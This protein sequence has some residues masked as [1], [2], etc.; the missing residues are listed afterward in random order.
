M[1]N[2]KI[3]IEVHVQLNTKS[4]LFC[5]CSNLES[6]EPNS[7]TCATCLGHPGSK[8]VLNKKAFEKAIKVAIALGCKINK[9]T[10]FSRKSYFYPDLAKNFQISQYEIPIG[11]AGKFEGINIRRLHLEED[12]A[13][14]IHKGSIS[15]IDYNRSGTPLIEIVTEPDFK[16]PNEVRLFLRKLITMLTYLDV[17]HKKG[18]STL[19]ADANIS[20]HGERVEIKNVNGLKDIERALEYEAKRQETELQEKQETRGWDSEK[21]KTYLMRVKESENDY[22]YIFEPDLPVFE[23]SKELLEKIKREIPELSI[24]KNKRYKKQHNLDDETAEVLSNDINLAELY[25]YLIEKGIKPEIAAKWL[26]RDLLG[27]LAYDEKELKDISLNQ[28]HL[29]DLLKLVQEN[30]I[31]DD[32]GKKLLL[33]LIKE[34]FDVD[35]KVKKE[36]L[37]SVSDEG[38]LEKA[39]KEVIKENQDAVEKVKKGDEKVLNFLM[40]Q[41]MRKT[42]GVGRPDVIIRILKKLI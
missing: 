38:V 10:F 33:E 23:I 5:S 31:T 15:L 40:G 3:G 2:L 9:E 12:P 36:G 8:P 35:K 4:K 22:G 16:S 42:K 13:A 6:D 29:F 28:N 37:E 7:R 39:C 25:E 26:R 21:G 24:D 19:K 32:V 34:D 17:Y 30:K 41:V 20:V 1:R 14:L 18:D 11:L 27:F